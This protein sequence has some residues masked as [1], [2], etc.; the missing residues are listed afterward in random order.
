[1]DVHRAGPELLGTGAS[2]V[3]GGGSIH[4]RS[5]RGVA[6]ERVCWDYSDAF[7]FPAVLGWRGDF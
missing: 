2:E 1:M 5:L 3:D 7:V 6:V 4:S